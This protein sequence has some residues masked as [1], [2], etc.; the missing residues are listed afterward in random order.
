VDPSRSED[1]A[2]FASVVRQLDEYFAGARTAFDLPLA[3]RG[4]PFQRRV[5]EELAR[6]PFGATVTYGELAARVG[7]PG[8]ARAV[9]A[10]VARNPISIVVPCHRVVGAD[11][12]LTGYAGGV[13]R[14]AYLLAHE[15]AS[16]AAPAPR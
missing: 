10:A 3:P 8:A 9:G 7:H 13:A 12:T 2:A 14:K 6:I 5:W 1:P 11:G 15:V 4:T 16:A